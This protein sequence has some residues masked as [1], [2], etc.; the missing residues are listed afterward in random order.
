MKKEVMRKVTIS[1][2]TRQRACSNG[3]RS[4]SDK[5][6]VFVWGKVSAT[7]TRPPWER[8]HPAPPWERGHLVRN[9]RAARKHVHPLSYIPTKPRAAETPI[10]RLSAET[11]L[12]R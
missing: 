7:V 1:A 10:G 4:S 3:Y 5:L 9:E 8:G 12:Y 2:A 6:Y 11:S